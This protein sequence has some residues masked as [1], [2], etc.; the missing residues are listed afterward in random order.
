MY[1]DRKTIHA[2]L[3]KTKSKILNAH[4]F[5]SLEGNEGKLQKFYEKSISIK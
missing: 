2:N 5:T 4:F 3:S 1:T